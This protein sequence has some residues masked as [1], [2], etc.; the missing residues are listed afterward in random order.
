MRAILHTEFDNAKSFYD[1]AT[2]EFLNDGKI[3]L[4]SYNQLVLSIKDNEV[5]DFP[6]EEHKLSMTT[7]RHTREFLRQNI[8]CNKSWTKKEIINLRDSLN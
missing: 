7:L 1:K 2:M 8:D 6:M 5:I 4:Y 3:N